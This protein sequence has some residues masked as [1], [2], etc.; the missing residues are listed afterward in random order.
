M[1]KIT[2]ETIY[3]Y[4]IGK[5]DYYVLRTATFNTDS[6]AEEKAV[7]FDIFNSKFNRLAMQLGVRWR[8]ASKDRLKEFEEQDRDVFLGEASPISVICGQVVLNH[9][10]EDYAAIWE[11]IDIEQV[12]HYKSILELPIERIVELEN[13]G[14]QFYAYY[15]GK[16]FYDEDESGKEINGEGPTF[17]DDDFNIHYMDVSKDRAKEIKTDLLIKGKPAIIGPHS[18]VKLVYDKAD[19][20]E[21]YVPNDDPNTVGIWFLTSIDEKCEYQELLDYQK[22]NKSLGLNLTPEAK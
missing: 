3:C 17:L 16:S 2:K 21:I 10:L 20:R 4:P 22:K 11:R 19:K 13:D 1:D 15:D 8:E 5:E 6:P 12:M 9:N 18:P 7:K 14:K